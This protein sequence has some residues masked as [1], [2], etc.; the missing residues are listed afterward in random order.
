MIA[1]TTRTTRSRVIVRLL[2]ELSGKGRDDGRPSLPGAWIRGGPPRRFPEPLVGHPLRPHQ[3]AGA[4]SAET[5]EGGGKEPG[6]LHAERIGEGRE[7]LAPG[8][9]L[10]VDHVVD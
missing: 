2:V 3:Q 7:V 8:Q 5:A 10:V 9:R 6:G 4:R 1:S